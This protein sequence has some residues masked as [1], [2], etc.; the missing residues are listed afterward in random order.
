MNVK[1]ITFAGL[2]NGINVADLLETRLVANVELAVKLFLISAY[3]FSGPIIFTGNVS[4]D[5]LVVDGYVEDLDI[6]GLLDDL[7]RVNDTS[8]DF[9]G[10]KSVDITGGQSV[11][12]TGG[13]SVD[14]TGEQSV[15]F[16]G[17]QSVD[18]T[19]EQSVDV[20]GGQ[21][22]DVTGGQR[23]DFTGGKALTS[24]FS[25]YQTVRNVQFFL[26]QTVRNV[27][28]FLYQT[29]RNVQFSLPE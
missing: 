12:F 11:D 14:I 27:Q 21:S 13:Q 24:Q 15:D 22:V 29:V 5:H 4:I 23:V 17:G 7:V 3:H 18:I 20:T 1:D 8:V 25:L 28:F 6:V 26:Y 2:F 16:T 10:E 9:T 19:G